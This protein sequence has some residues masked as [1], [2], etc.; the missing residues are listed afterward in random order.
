[1]L[2]GRQPSGPH[3]RGSTPRTPPGA[4][5]APLEVPLTDDV[6]VVHG[7]APLH[8]QIRVRGAKNLVSKAMVAALLG[9]TPS[10]L[11][12]VP[13]IRDVEVVRGL[14]ELHGVKVSDGADD[15]E[16]VM[17]PTNVETRQHRRD[18]RARR[19]EPDPDPALRPAAAPARSR[20]HP[21]PGRLPHRPAPDRLPH[22]GAARVRRDRRQDARGHAPDR[23][24][25]GC[26]APSWSCRTRASARPSRC[27]SPRSAPRASP[28]CA[29]RPS[30]RRSST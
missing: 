25:T 11:F 6:L 28:S 12:D 8:G 9:E 13:R 24:R 4:E 29:T 3:P 14:L 17:D 15:G 5:R 27:C 26:T 16:L 10:R 21:G 22:P 7:G 30:S 23:A 2:P 18:Q 19:L 1:M 20:V